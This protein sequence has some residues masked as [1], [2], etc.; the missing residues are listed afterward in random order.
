MRV[1][2]T[3]FYQLFKILSTDKAK[4][5]CFNLQ[6]SPPAEVDHLLLL[7]FMDGMLIHT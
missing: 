6:P 5:L 1:P 7:T 4:T 3:Q 2:I